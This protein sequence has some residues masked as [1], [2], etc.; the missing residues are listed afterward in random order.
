MRDAAKGQAVVDELGAASKY[1]VCDLSNPK[2]INALAEKYKDEPV[3]VLIN[4]AAM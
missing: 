2:D 3:H 1:A 4:N